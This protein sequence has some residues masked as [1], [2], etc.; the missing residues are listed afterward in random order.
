MFRYCVLEFK[1][2]W[3]KYFPLVEFAYNNSFQSRIK[4]ASNEALYDRRLKVSP[5]KKILRF[6]L[7]SKLSLRFIGHMKSLKE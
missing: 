7:K 4:M 2:N 1:G 3:E 6:G 5:W